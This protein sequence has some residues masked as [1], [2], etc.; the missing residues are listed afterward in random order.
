MMKM[1]YCGNISGGHKCNLAA[2]HTGEHFHAGVGWTNTDS[3]ADLI[4]ELGQSTLPDG[5][6]LQVLIHLNIR[7]ARTI[8]TLLAAHLAVGTSK[9]HKPGGKT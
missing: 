7:M 6:R 4:S 3:V 2:G 5:E 9:K 1:I 8:E